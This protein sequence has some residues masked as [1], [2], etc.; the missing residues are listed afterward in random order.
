MDQGE[1]L[2][3]APPRPWG[4]LATL[5]WVLLA[6]ALTTAVSTAA[7]ALWGSEQ[8]EDSADRLADIPLLAQLALVSTAIEIGVVGFAA[9]LAH[10]R[11]RNYLGL[12][13]PAARAALIPLAIT[14]VF[15][16]GNDAMSLALNHDVVSP[17][18]IETYRSARAAGLLPILWIALLIVGPLGEEIVFRGFLFRGWAQSPR[19]I[20]PAI[21]VISALWAMMHVQ[22]GWFEILQI[23]V[24]GLLLGWARWRSGSTLLTFGLHGLVNA[25][26]T[27]ETIVKVG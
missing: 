16:V 8:L 27:I 3:L 6:V 4:Y 12:V 7:L 5:A 1:T 14:A 22:Y 26:A 23:F 15:V 21:V 9:R 18:Q 19:S 13:F 17:F 24:L 20:A 2:A 10:W 11:A 25:W